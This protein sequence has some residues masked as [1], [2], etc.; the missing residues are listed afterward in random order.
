MLRHLP[1]ITAIAL[2]GATLAGVAA[3]A[4]KPTAQQ[5]VQN[6][7]VQTVWPLPPD[8]PRVKFV[9]TFATS[10]DVG[11]T[12]KTK[13]LAWKETLLGK[14]AVAAE[15]PPIRSFLKPFGVALDGF[16]RI[17]V[18][19]PARAAVVV[20]DP[21]GRMFTPIGEAQK[22]AHFRIPMGIA[23]DA[24]NNIYVGDNGHKQ[25]LVFGPDLGFRFAIRGGLEAPSGLAMDNDRNRLYVVDTRLHGVMVY[26]P[27]T[28]KRIGQLMKR[29]EGNGEFNF[30]TGVAVGPDGN[31][32]VTDSMNQRIEV[33]TPAL[34]FVRAFGS[35]GDRPGQFRRPKGIAVD[36][37]GVVFVVDSDYCNVQMF[38]PDGKVLMF[39]GGPG[40]R[41][42]QMILPAGIAIDRQSRRIYVCE[43]QNKRVQVFER[44][45]PALSAAEARRP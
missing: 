9:G 11:A 36:A 4:Q 8:V 17:I 1:G 24:A 6:T 7:P 44:V 42:G 30:P 21:A 2:A 29:G 41:P 12:R 39:V 34:K 31:V 16:G 35:P 3:S 18:T 19:D 40:P 27:A 45:G 14:A 28:G 15:R 20:M 38:S 10:D 25:I 22:Q 43:Q 37:D 5:Q 26:D 32:Y 23:V 33:F 13:A